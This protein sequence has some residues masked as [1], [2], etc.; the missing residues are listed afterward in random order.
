MLLSRIWIWTAA[1]DADYSMALT[2]HFLWERVSEFLLG[3]IVCGSFGNKRWTTAKWC[4]S[5][6]PKWTI[7]SHQSLQT[8]PTLVIL[9]P[10]YVNPMSWGRQAGV[11]PATDTWLNQDQVGVTL[12]SWHGGP[13]G[14]ECRRM[15]ADLSVMKSPWFSSISSV[16]SLSCVQLFETPWT[17]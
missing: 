12:G 13:K 2:L 14:D 11:F 5:Q 3:L 4:M 9:P 6:V 10:S 1:K 7:T 15:I 8:V 17:I 16:Q